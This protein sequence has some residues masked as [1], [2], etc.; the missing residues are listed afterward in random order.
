MKPPTIISASAG[1]GKTHRLATQLTNSVEKEGIKPDGVVATTFTNKAAAELKERVRTHLLK[2][3]R[4]EAAERL[5]FARIGTVNSICS[6]L[7]SEYA[8]ELGVSPE[9]SVLDEA[10]S[11]MVFDRALSMALA[12]GEDIELE[13]I[14]SRMKGLKWK[15]DVRR[16]VNLARSNRIDASELRTMATRSTESILTLFSQG[17]PL[18]SDI[19]KE[20]LAALDVLI[21]QAQAKAKTRKKEHKKA[22][23]AV[24]RLQKIAAILRAEESLAWSEWLRL[25]K[26]DIAADLTEEV[27]P[28]RAIAER[29]ERHPKLTEDC[30]KVIE[31]V[32]KTAEK[33]NRCLPGIQA[34]PRVHRLCRSGGTGAYALAARGC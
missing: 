28:V 15:E 29:H 26:L 9:L 5:A 6:R 12:Q 23:N 24:E 25:S 10:Q 22:G 19:E 11:E 31:L 3:G 27:K 8:F 18:D 34:R 13:K 4:K 7:L 17:D 20:L 1:T 33:C 2:A 14:G 32:F 16:I 30:R 21:S